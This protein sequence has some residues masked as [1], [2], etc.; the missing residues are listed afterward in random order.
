MKP[1]TILAV[2]LLAVFPQGCVAGTRYSGSKPVG[3]D[4][5]D[6]WRPT[7]VARV[8]MEGADLAIQV[9]NVR[10]TRNQIELILPI[11]PLPGAVPLK[12]PLKVWVGITPGESPVSF[13]PGQVTLETDDG[14][15]L[16]PTGFWGP[17]TGGQKMWG[18]PWFHYACGIPRK[19]L[20]EKKASRPMTERMIRYRENFNTPRSKT[21]VRPADRSVLVPE[22]ACFVLLFDTSPSPKRGFTLKMDGIMVFDEPAP[23]PE[24]RFS[25]G[26]SWIW[27]LLYPC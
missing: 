3:T 19:P 25:R 23:V 24:I 1:E 22:P 11:I 14:E 13:D 5:K 18:G 2:V 9:K 8:S 21:P 26:D 12:P 10:P 7:L 20:K 4:Y 15:V 6:E 27:E 17:G 16:H